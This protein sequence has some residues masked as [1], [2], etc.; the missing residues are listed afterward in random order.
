MK[1]YSGLAVITIPLFILF[2]ILNFLPKQTGMALVREGG[3]IENVSVI[4]YFVGVAIAIIIAARMKWPAGYSIGIIMMLLAFRELDFDTRF[5]TRGILSISFYLNPVVGTL[6]RIIVIL[7]ML[8]LS[9]FLFMFLKKYTLAFMDGL[10]RGVPYF[11]TASAGIIS[12]PLSY[13]IDGGFEWLDNMGQGYRSLFIEEPLEMA[14]PFFFILAMIQFY[15]NVKN[16]EGRDPIV[17]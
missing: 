10:R 14:I 13:Y 1:I 2:L 3:L 5:T 6:E 16:Q 12:L 15:I 8:L 4:G 17:S 7:I 11:I 9:A